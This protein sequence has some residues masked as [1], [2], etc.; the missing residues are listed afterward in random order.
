MV[1]SLVAGGLWVSGVLDTGLTGRAE[2]ASDGR[3]RSP[4]QEVPTASIT[5]DAGAVPIDADWADAA[6]PSPESKYSGMF[7]GMADVELLLPLR[8]SPIA[9]VK[10][11]KG[12]SSI[13][14]RIDFENGARAAFKPNQSNWQSV[15]RR[16]IAAYRLNRMLGLNSVPPAIGRSF[17]LKDILGAMEPSSV[18]FKPRMRAEIVQTEDRVVGEL[19]WWIPVI[20]HGTID[21]YKIDSMEGIVSWKRYLRVG[22]RFPEAS[23]AILEQISDLVLFDFVINNPDRWSGGNARVNDD[24]S[25]LYFMDNTMSFGK[26]KMGHR[27]SRIYFQ[28]CQMF[29]RRLVEKLREMDETTLREILEFDVEPFD[30]FLE[31]AEIIALMSRRDLALEYIDALIRKY[32][33]EKVLAFP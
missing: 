30:F 15:P 18:G 1:S 31:D 20:R 22:G 9:S 21:G 8:D 4:T 7:N 13:S 17:T 25:I 33:E 32:G 6:P 29:S 24:R 28:R 27:K 5:T 10:F 12:G 11:N 16:E 2:A 26:S 19:S 14:L 23:R 3:L